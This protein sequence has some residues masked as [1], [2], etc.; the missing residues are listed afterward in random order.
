MKQF[1]RLEQFRTAV[2]ET[3]AYLHEFR[4]DVDYFTH[5]PHQD[6]KSL[7]NIVST[8]IKLVLQESGQSD[9]TT[10]TAR[11]AFG[12][13]SLLILPPYTVYS[14]NTYDGVDSFEIFFNIHPITREQEFLHQLGLDKALLFP[15]LL[16]RA[17]F[18]Q[19]RDCFSAI[20][21]QSDGAYAQLQALLSTLLIR[22]CRTQGARHPAS[23]AGSREQAVIEKFFAYLTRHIGEP[24][25][26]ASVCRDL[27]ISQSYL[28]RCCKSVMNCSSSQLITR[29]KMIHAQTLLKNPDLTISEVAEAVGY[30]PYYFSNQFKKLF[31]LSPSE[32]RKMQR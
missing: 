26:I 6:R 17:D 19:L 18:D 21:Q 29:H 12:P 31:L 13:G 23:C 14:A 30:D 27:Q 7:R 25:Q 10:Q 16:T 9:L 5:W 22:V 8:R 28:Y 11:F 24:I 4:F 3:S 20:R 15:D 1:P 32:Y 2:D